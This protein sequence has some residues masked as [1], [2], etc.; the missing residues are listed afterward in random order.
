MCNVYVKIL[1]NVDIFI[2][3]AISYGSNIKYKFD[4]PICLLCSS[5][6]FIALHIKLD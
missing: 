4:Y 5:K 2:A 1:D 6:V 3:A